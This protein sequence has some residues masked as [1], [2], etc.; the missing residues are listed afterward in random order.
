VGLFDFL[1]RKPSRERFASIA[2][3]MLRKQNPTLD[4]EFDAD[5]FAIY[6]KSNAKG[7]ITASL[8]N[9][10]V[11]YCAA[12]RRDRDSVLRRYFAGIA[13]SSTGLPEN[14]LQAKPHLLPLIRSAYEDSNWSHF[15]RTTDGDRIPSIASKPLCADIVVQIGFDTETNIARVS[16]DQ[17]EKWDVEF[18]EAL[19]D[20]VNNLRIKTGDKWHQIGPG[21]FVGAWEDYYDASRILLPDALY[22]LNLSG[23]PIVF[24]PSRETLIVTGS[25]DTNAQ[26]IAIELALKIY[27]ER[28]RRISMTALAHVD[29][30]WKSFAPEGETGMRLFTLQKAILAEE[31]ETQKE[32]LQKAMEEAGDDVFVASVM[33]IKQN[34]GEEIFSLCSWTDGVD[35][36]LPVTDLLAFGRLGEDQKLSKSATVPWEVAVKHAGHLLE[37]TPYLPTRFRVRSFPDEATFDALICESVM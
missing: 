6:L 10:Y 11:D 3:G 25:R 37:S 29:G 24:I 35:T 27:S 5:Q 26:S 32:D 13:Q 4:F 9:V 16:N 2:M 30:Q 31:Y 12:E 7:A 8:H 28:P 36:L 15:L 1:N 18:E 34:H 23:D 14:Y 20:A 21:V 17:L 33:R 22:R 19:G